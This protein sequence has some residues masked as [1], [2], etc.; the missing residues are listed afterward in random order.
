MTGQHFVLEAS[1]QRHLSSRGRLLQSQDYS[2]HA[3]IGSTPA[4]C[5][6]R[7]FIKG[8]QLWQMF[9]FPALSEAPFINNA[10]RLA[11]ASLLKGI[12]NC[13]EWCYIRTK[14]FWKNRPTGT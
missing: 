3:S 2:I 8:R 10:C 7:D 12:V 5:F 1:G 4:S 14:L 11:Y 9:P 13:A 6:L